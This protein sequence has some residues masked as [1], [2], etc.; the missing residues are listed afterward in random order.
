MATIAPLAP[1]VEVEG[2]N[3]YYGPPPGGHLV[4]EGVNLTIGQNEVVGL[5]GR[6]GSGKSTLLR[7]IAGL[8]HPREG[9]VRFVP[10]EDCPDPSVSMVFQ[11]FALFPWLTVQENVELGLEAQ[12]VPAEERRAR[13]LAAIDLI[14]LDGFESAYPKELSGGM[15]QRVGFAR[16]LVV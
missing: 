1:L 14:G 12:K 10:T 9:E 13:A 3:H 4:L 8:I 6:S 11:T 7:S 15:R 2:L 5:L 16:A